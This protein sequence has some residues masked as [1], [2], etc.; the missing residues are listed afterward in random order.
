MAVYSYTIV[1]IKIQALIRSSEYYHN[2][3]DLHLGAIGQATK[4]IVGTP[5]ARI[6]TKS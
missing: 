4:G 3:Q 6:R 1:L 2:E 5:N